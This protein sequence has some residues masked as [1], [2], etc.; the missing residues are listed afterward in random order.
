MIKKLGLLRNGAYFLDR[1]PEWFKTILN[2]LRYI[3]SVGR[4]LIF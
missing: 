2:Y 3:F 1:D 4:Q